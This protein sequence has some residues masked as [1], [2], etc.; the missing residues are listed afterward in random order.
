MCADR[1]HFITYWL[2]TINAL[3]KSKLEREWV[4]ERRAFFNYN[5][6]T[7]SWPVMCAIRTFCPLLCVC[8]CARAPKPP[9]NQKHAVDMRVP[10]NST[11]AGRF[12]IH[13]RPGAGRAGAMWR[14]AIMWCHVIDTRFQSPQ[15]ADQYMTVWNLTTA[16]R[17]HP[18]TISKM[19]VRM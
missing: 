1:T 13:R 3:F 14:E 6:S 19:L 2:Y 9:I 7:L 8:V 5:I 18:L 17:C 15:P 11:R 16:N 10:R 12:M 4:S